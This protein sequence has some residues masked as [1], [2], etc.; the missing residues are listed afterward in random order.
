MLCYKVGTKVV[1]KSGIIVAP[2]WFEDEFVVI[3][4]FRRYGQP[5]EHYMVGNK[6]GTHYS[7]VH[8]WDIDHVAT[9]NLNTN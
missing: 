2:F 8:E 5:G 3:K 9:D 4:D 1:L 7:Y 6:D